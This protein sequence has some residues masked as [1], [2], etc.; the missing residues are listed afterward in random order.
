MNYYECIQNAIDYVENNPENSI[1][2]TAAAQK[3]YMS[4]SHFYR[5]FLL[6][7]ATPLKIKLG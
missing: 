1:D 3:A 2:I 5:F 4:L 7:P 6:S